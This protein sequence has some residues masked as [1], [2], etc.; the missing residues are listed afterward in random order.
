MEESRGRSDASALAT[1]CH[2]TLV[3]LDEARLHC[4]L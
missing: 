3:K 2:G 4:L 1:N